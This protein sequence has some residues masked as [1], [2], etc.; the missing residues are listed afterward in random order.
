M[1]KKLLIN[2]FIEKKLTYRWFI[3]GPAWSYLDIVSSLL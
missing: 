3:L 1:I 2:S